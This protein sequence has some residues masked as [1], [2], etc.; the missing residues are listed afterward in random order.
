MSDISY[1]DFDVPDEII[2]DECE[3]DCIPKIA[4]IILPIQEPIVCAALCTLSNI[5]AIIISNGEYGT[6][7]FLPDT[8]NKHSEH[9]VVGLTKLVQDMDAVLIQYVFGRI[10]AS[11]YKNGAKMHSLIPTLVISNFSDFAE[12]V[13]MGEIDPFDESIYKTSKKNTK[14]NKNSYY[15]YCD[16]IMD[17]DQLQEI[18]DTSKISQLDADI[19][20]SKFHTV[21]EDDDTIGTDNK[22]ANKRWLP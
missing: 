13:L 21:D 10:D 9:S 14:S 6:L 17:D 4:L 5:H 8:G 16:Y 18:L 2:N 1:L 3:V 15:N 7:A 11:L 20:L 19:I 12:K 22:T